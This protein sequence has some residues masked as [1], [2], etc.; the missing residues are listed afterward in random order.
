MK[1]IDSTLRAHLDL[2]V[3]SLCTLWRITRQ[4]GIE[5]YLTDHDVDIPFDDGDGEQTYLS[6]EGYSRTAVTNNVGLSVDNMDM[7]GI[8]SSIGVKEDEIR[9]GLFD[10]AE[11]K[12]NI[13]NWSD[14]SQGAIKM[15]RGRIGQVSLNPSGAFSAELRGLVSPLS[16]NIVTNYQSECRVDLGS[17]ACGVP[18]RPSVRIDT[19]LV[20]VGEFRRVATKVLTPIAWG[21]TVGNHSFE[22]STA[23]IDVSNIS[24]WTIVSGE[25]DIT[26]TVDGLSA[27]DGSQF[28]RGGQNSTQSQILQD[29][30]LAS[31]GLDLDSV[32]AGNVTASFSIR[33]ANTDI[34]DTGRVLVTF[35][36]SLGAPIGT[37]YDSGTETITPVDTWATRSAS[38]VA[39]PTTT[40]QIRI[41]LY[42]N[43]VTGTQQDSC[44]DTL[45]LTFSDTS[46]SNTFQDIYENIH[47]ECI[48]A[49]TTSGTE[50]VFDT[51]E[52]NETI[53]GTVTFIA[54]NAWTRDGYIHETTNKFNFQV[55]YTEPR[56]IDE[57]FSGGAIVIESGP[58]TGSVREIKSWVESGGLLEIFIP[59]P[60]EITP[61]TKVKIYPGCD[62]RHTTCRTKFTN[63][64][65]F[66]GEPFVPGT[67]ALGGTG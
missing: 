5:I 37:I 53:D 4:D 42:S 1:S 59:M 40:R 33:R 57:W 61:G 50:P 20:L 63:I 12:V 35:L 48:T 49:G 28:L 67:D 34:N 15:R 64:L 3:T 66:R 23:G 8:F 55:T 56:A 27:D 6:D 60:F 52:P 17:T 9:V 24:R 26:T 21:N 29:V 58:N 39:V 47:Y 46:T 30:T 36:D 7:Q 19:E 22:N 25:W 62:K 41:Q 32:D 51:T 16:Q 10:Y 38:I 43:L 65:N 11:V 18:I 2:T 45:D 44:F 14:T 54:R 13:I 31:F